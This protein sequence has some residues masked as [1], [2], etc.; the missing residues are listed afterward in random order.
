MLEQPHQS[1]INQSERNQTEEEKK[2]VKDSQW[3][4]KLCCQL[5]QESF[6]PEGKMLEI[7][8]LVRER[9]DI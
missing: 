9:L 7:R 4:Q 5:L 6:V 3:I 1:F 8:Y 2:D